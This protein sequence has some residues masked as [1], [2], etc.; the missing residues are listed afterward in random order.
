MSESQDIQ[1]KLLSIC[2]QHDAANVVLG[3]AVVIGRLGFFVQSVEMARIGDEIARQA[4][5][6]RPSICG[7]IC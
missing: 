3:L 6:S 4:R 2:A 7:G 1:D 5:G